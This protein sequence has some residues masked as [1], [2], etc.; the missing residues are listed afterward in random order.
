[1]VPPGFL[2]RTHPTSLSL[3]PPGFS[4]CM[5]PMWLSLGLCSPICIAGLLH[6]PQHLRMEVKCLVWELFNYAGKLC[7]KESEFE[8]FCFHFYFFLSWTDL[9]DNV[10][11]PYR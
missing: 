9:G 8:V 1:M 11:P 4:H 3:V 6:P 10:L 5:V 2:Y 7:P